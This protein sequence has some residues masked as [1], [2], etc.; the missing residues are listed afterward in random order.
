[1]NLS[2]VFVFANGHES[3]KLK[4]KCLRSVVY[5]TSAHPS[6]FNRSYTLLETH[7]TYRT[8]PSIILLDV[9]ARIQISRKIPQVLRIRKIEHTRVVSYQTHYMRHYLAVQSA[10]PIVEVSQ[11]HGLV[12]GSNLDGT[13]K[14]ANEIVVNVVEGST[15]R[16]LFTLLFVWTGSC[17]GHHQDGVPTSEQSHTTSS[18]R[19]LS[20][21]N[22]LDNVSI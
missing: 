4:K 18:A 14:S 15:R 6:Y 12:L 3:V 5:F 16:I 11:C 22:S 20:L 17:R 1:M 9:Y 19:I 7:H 13:A 2:F 10:C 8:I 21:S